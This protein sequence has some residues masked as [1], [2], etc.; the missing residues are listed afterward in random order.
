MFVHGQTYQAHPVACAAALEVQRVIQAE[1]LLGNVVE[2][3][4]QL[5]RLLMAR[6]ASH[7]HVGDIRGA[8][9]FWGIE[10][11]EDKDSK[12]AFP[13][14]DAVASSISQLALTENYGLTVY[15]GSGTVDGKVGDHIILAPPYTISEEEVKFIAETVQRLV[16]DFFLVEYGSNILPVD[17]VSESAETC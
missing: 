17:R 7:P 5:S 11:V 3:G 8:G 10:F 14:V 1:N 4:G 13:K 6:L 16:H 2:R 12:R 9:L 15:E